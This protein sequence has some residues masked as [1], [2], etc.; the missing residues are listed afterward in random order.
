MARFVLLIALVVVASG[1]FAQTTP[2]DFTPIPLAQPTAEI[3]PSGTSGSADRQALVADSVRMILKPFIR[4]VYEFPYYS[5]GAGAYAIWPDVRSQYITP[6]SYSDYSRV[7]TEGMYV[8]FGWG[9][10]L[11]D[12]ESGLR[13]PDGYYGHNPAFGTGSQSGSPVDCSEYYEIYLRFLTGEPSGLN[14]APYRITEWYAVHFV[15]EDTPFALFEWEQTEGLTIRLDGTDSYLATTD[16]HRPVH[17]YQWSYGDNPTAAVTQHT[18]LN[19]GEYAVT[20]TVT[21]EEGT[22]S[23]LTRTVVVTS[24]QLTVETRPLEPGRA[25]VEGDTVFVETTVTNTGESSVIDVSVRPGDVAAISRREDAPPNMGVYS[26]E[27]TRLREDFT[28]LERGVLPVGDAITFRDSLLVER[29]PRYVNSEGEQVPFEAEAYAEYYGSIQATSLIDEP[30][31]IRIACREGSC[32]NTFLVGPARYEV[33]LTTLSLSGGEDGVRAGLLS[34]PTWDLVSFAQFEPDGSGG[35]IPKCITGC[36]E[37]E[38]AVTTEHD[39]ASVEG[40][41]VQFT[42]M[43]P[44][45]TSV[46]FGG[47]FACERVSINLSATCTSDPAGSVFIEVETDEDGMAFAWYAVPGGL[48][49]NITLQ[50]KAEVENPAGDL[51]EEEVTVSVAIESLSDE[52]FTL[53][54]QSSTYGRVLHNVSNAVGFVTLGEYC[55]SFVKWV[56]DEGINELGMAR[57][58][59]NYLQ[60]AVSGLPAWMCDAGMALVGEAGPVG[61]LLAGINTVGDPTKKAVDL[62]RFFWFAQAFELDKA[63]DLVDLQGPLPPPIVIWYDGD[64]NDFV[65]EATGLAT[66]STPN[67]PSPGNRLVLKEVSGIIPVET[68]PVMALH[69]RPTSRSGALRMEYT[70]PRGNANAILSYGYKPVADVVS[71]G[72]DGFLVANGMFAAATGPLA[73]TDERT[74]L[75]SRDG[76]TINSIYVEIATSPINAGDVTISL[77]NWDGETGDYIYLEPSGGGDIA[78]VHQV[79][80]VEGSPQAAQRGRASRSATRVLS[81]GVTL[82]LAAPVAFDYGEEAQVYWVAEG[83]IAP[84]PPPILQTILGPEAPEM[85]AWIPAP[86]TVAMSFDL[87]LARDSLF[88]DLLIDEA[89]LTDS[90][91]AVQG[92]EFEHDST[93]YW[94]ARASNR[95]GESEWSR[96]QRFTPGTTIVSTEEGPGDGPAE[97]VPEAFALSGGQPNPFHGSTTLVLTMPEGSRVEV[98]VYDLLGRE[99]AVLADA[100]MPAGTHRLAFEGRGLPSGVYLVRMVA[101]DFVATQ[102]VTLLR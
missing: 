76:G 61:G 92:Y 59:R 20:L 71:I 43:T 85:L 8:P 33:E 41:G 75:E 73:S 48:E 22:E 66:V 17:T 82:E 57:Y 6:T 2:Q 101:D 60:M 18:F 3:S 9:Q 93:Y 99:V 54:A 30:V 51:I 28:P 94:Q 46:E 42:V 56:R 78:E 39:G 15:P 29:A 69:F 67:T 19:P 79:I 24:H 4:Y 21:N 49:E 47:G 62:L 44:L 14:G 32:G 98:V 74:R 35:T 37:L 102:R 13:V 53:S 100:Q 86:P 12:P 25:Y 38:A 63:S 77:A 55:E 1:S 72:S 58:R 10:Q 90:E 70:S 89:D 81:G 83:E 16:G 87:Q 23:H 11:D 68:G 7:A 65:D 84:P 40:V 64:I 31:D 91:F 26:A 95:I 27:L 45:G 80:G 96:W 34:A 36:V 52:T 5:C 88:T 50:V 97:T